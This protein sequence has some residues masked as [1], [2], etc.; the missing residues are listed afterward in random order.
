MWK[1]K[2]RATDQDKEGKRMKSKRFL[3]NLVPA[4][5]RSAYKRRWF[6][7]N[8]QTKVL[9]YFAKPDK[10]EEK[11]QISLSDIRSVSCLPPNGQATP[12]EYNIH[13][14]TKNRVWNFSTDTGTEQT[15]WIAVFQHCVNMN[16]QLVI[17]ESPKIAVLGGGEM[18]VSRSSGGGGGGGTI[19]TEDHDDSEEEEVEDVKVPPAPPVTTGARL[20]KARSG[21]EGKLRRY[22]LLA[23]GAG[24]GGGAR[25]EKKEGLGITV[26]GEK[27]RNLSF[28]EHVK[29]FEW[30]NL[31]GNG[32][33][34]SR[35]ICVNREVE[36]APA[37]Q[38][39]GEVEGG[40]DEGGELVKD[41]EEVVVVKKE[42]EEEVPAPP[43]APPVPPESP[44]PPPPPVKERRNSLNNNDASLRVEDEDI[45]PSPKEVA[46]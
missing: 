14:L 7:L 35:D 6:V 41:E 33:L 1:R 3:G 36:P 45:P 29:F 13:L 18:G 34:A 22:S 32:D 21:V 24:G 40:Q 39:E 27:M 4:F 28:E 5:V 42:E 30:G 11:G 9:K 12:T 20:L 31:S 19:V 37:P 8:T 46:L 43:P 16:K 15:I 25:E 23:G 2:P 17:R 38:Y 44:A 10:K 26:N